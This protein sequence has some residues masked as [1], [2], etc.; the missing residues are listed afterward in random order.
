MKNLSF[1][2]ANMSS[3]PSPAPPLSVELS[4]G[5]T[6]IVAVVAAGATMGSWFLLKMFLMVTA[7]A[8]VDERGRQLMSTPGVRGG[9]RPLPLP[10]RSGPTLSQ[11]HS[12]SPCPAGRV[13]TQSARPR[14]LCVPTRH[15][16]AS[17][18]WQLP[19]PLPA[20][21]FPAD[22]H[23]RRCSSARSPVTLA[24]APQP[25]DPRAPP[26]GPTYL[27]PRHASPTLWLLL[28]VPCP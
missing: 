12:G 19:S 23:S 21:L 28:V 22:P 2:F 3:L 10:V 18:P 1:I 5:P 27:P 26:P 13:L 9:E 8:A 25:Q 11:I 14:L 16:L 20:M 17:E 7:G 4:T 15:P 6:G 24:S